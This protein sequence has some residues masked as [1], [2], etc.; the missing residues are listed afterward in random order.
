MALDDE[1]SLWDWLLFGWLLVSSSII[2][3]IMV[4]VSLNRNKYI[5]L[6]Y[7]HPF[8]IYALGFFGLVSTWSSFIAND[9]LSII[10]SLRQGYCPLWSYWMSHVFGLNMWFTIMML[11]LIDKMF[12][13]HRSFNHWQDDHKN[14]VRVFI[15]FLLIFFPVILSTVVTTGG[16]SHWNTTT[17]SCESSLVAKVLLIVW[18]CVSFLLFNITFILLEKDIV[19]IFFVEY[20]ALSHITGIFQ[21]VF[22][23]NICVNLFG[24]IHYNYGRI[25]YTFN[26]NMLFLFT[27]LRINGYAI[28]KVLKKDFKYDEEINTNSVLYNIR[29]VSVAELMPDPFLSKAYV[30]FADDNMQTR[31]ASSSYTSRC[32]TFNNIVDCINDILQHKHVARNRNAAEKAIISTFFDVNASRAIHVDHAS[33]LTIIINKDLELAYTKLCAILDDDYYGREFLKKLDE[34]P[35]LILGELSHLAYRHRHHIPHKKLKHGIRPLKAYQLRAGIQQTTTTTE[36]S[37]EEEMMNTR[38]RKPHPHEEI[39]NGLSFEIIDIE[40]NKIDDDEEEEEEEEEE[41]EEDPKGLVMKPEPIFIDRNA[42]VS[43]EEEERRIAFLN[44]NNNNNKK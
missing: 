5:L 31:N 44:N 35:E 41:G 34:G 26:I 13:L 39:C 20:L 24:A 33:R 17:H 18:Y 40:K 11:R 2:V 38:R 42:E 8:A 4:I 37:E 25:I 27:L 9:H 6:R 36:D 15:F 21:I 12:I 29:Y 22:I 43:A 10:D 32:F 30:C 23:A 16:L 14:A 28:F 19:N 3:G 7:K 1:D